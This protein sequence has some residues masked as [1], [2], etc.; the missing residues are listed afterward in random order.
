MNYIDLIII[1]ILSVSVFRGFELGFVRQLLSTLG[2]FMGL[3]IGVLLEPY[4]V[5]LVSTQAS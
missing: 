5:S 2:F 4:T 3:L 1:I